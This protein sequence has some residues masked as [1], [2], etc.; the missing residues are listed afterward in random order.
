MNLIY[1]SLMR[2]Y[3]AA[4]DEMDMY[5]DDTLEQLVMGSEITRYRLQSTVFP[6]EGVSIPSYKGSMS[7]RI[8]GTD[9]MSRYARLLFRFGEYSGVGIKSSIGMGAMRIVE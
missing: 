9:T 7:V 4:S 5:D 3:S 1:K 2:K 8:H 6:L